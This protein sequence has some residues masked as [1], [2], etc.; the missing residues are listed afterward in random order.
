MRAPRV[1]C[2]LR[3]ERIRAG[4]G[5]IFGGWR[6][7]GCLVGLRR[8]HLRLRRDQLRLGAQRAARHGPLPAVEQQRCQQAELHCLEQQQ[9]AHGQDQ[10]P[11]RDTDALALGGRPALGLQLV[12]DPLQ[13]AQDALV[14]GGRLR[15]CGGWRHR[16][17]GSLCAARGIRCVR[18]GLGGLVRRPGGLRCRRWARDHGALLP[19]ASQREPSG[20]VF[21]SIRSVLG[22]WGHL[23]RFLVLRDGVGGLRPGGF[24]GDRCPGVRLLGRGGLRGRTGCCGRSGLAL[25]GCPVEAGGGDRALQLPVAANHAIEGLGHV[26]GAGE[27]LRWIDGQGFV[28]QLQDDLFQLLL[29][30]RIRLAED[31][32]QGFGDGPAVLVGQAYRRR[33]LVDIEGFAREGVGL[34]FSQVGDRGHAVAAELDVV[35]AVERHLGAAQQVAAHPQQGEEGDANRPGVHGLREELAGVEEHLGRDEVL[36]AQD[37]P[38]GLPGRHLEGAP[39]GGPE[40]DQQ[41]APVVG[42][43]GVARLDVG[44]HGPHAL[45]GHEGVVFRDT[46]ADVGQGAA[47]RLHGVREHVHLLP[48]AFHVGGA[49]LHHHADGVIPLHHQ[50]VETGTGRGGL[51]LL[52]G[53]EDLHLPLH[54][55]AGEAFVD[56]DLER[57]DR[58]LGHVAVAAGRTHGVHAVDD[59]HAAGTRGMG[60]VAAIAA[61]R[62]AGP[63]LYRSSDLLR[64]A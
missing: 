34:A 11:H 4:S 38:G 21:L 46:P 12:L 57:Q 3:Q 56:T 42:Q 6:F 26:L 27:A 49:P 60:R 45:A 36:G 9:Q 24:R 63:G 59:R 33:E 20:A 13:Q 48:P 41:P 62:L 2:D 52:Q 15:G 7:L 1:F 55:L 28:Q 14:D 54:G 23:G 18:D 39:L 22:F 58:A 64:T 5:F 50:V 40:I 29:A 8:A 31:A 17:G 43:H 35:G 16:P 25:D 47:E 61:A 53:L 51:G 30:W 10:Q 44:V 32:F 37:D 19:M